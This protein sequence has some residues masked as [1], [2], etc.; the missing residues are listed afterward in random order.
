MMPHPI[1]CGIF[2]GSGYIGNIENTKII[3]N[4]KNIRFLSKCGKMA[5]FS[6]KTENL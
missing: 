1:G 2:Y 4:I 3:E 6:K 5:C